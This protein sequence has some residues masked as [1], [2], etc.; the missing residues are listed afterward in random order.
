V[1]IST[2]DNIGEAFQSRGVKMKKPLILFPFL[3]AI[4]TI[5]LVYGLNGNQIHIRWLVRPFSVILL[6]SALV[7]WLARWMHR[8]RLRAG[9]TST[10][11]LLWLFSGH[12]H[13]AL[14]GMG[15]FASHP[16]RGLVL[17]AAW[18]SLLVFLGSRTLWQH[19]REQKR[20]TTYLNA[21]AVILLVFPSYRTFEFWGAIREKID[22]MEARRSQLPPLQL[23]PVSPPPDIYFIVLDAYGRADFLEEVYGYDNTEFIEFLVEKGFYVADRSS[24]NYPQTQLS[25]T[26]SLN[27]TYLND[28]TEGL[29]GSANR[30]PLNEMLQ[31]NT[32][33]QSLKNAGYSV[34]GLPS[35]VMFSRFSSADLY[36]PLT[37][38]EL[39]DFEQL[40]LSTTVA[41]VL[42]STGNLE[43]L[44]PGYET[45][46]VYI[47][48]ALETLKAVPVVPG[49]KFV[50]AHILA[51]HPPF[52]FDQYGNAVQPGY[53]YNMWD[54]AGFSGTREEYIA[55]YKNELTYLNQSLMDVISTILAE[56]RQPPIIII[57]GDHGPGAY[58]SFEELSKEG[59]L[60][61]R[62]SILNAYYFPGQQT[63][64]LYPTITPVNSFRVLFNTYFGTDLPILEDKNYYAAWLKPYEY[65]EIT[66]N[67]SQSASLCRQD[68]FND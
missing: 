47:K 17:L 30:A 8:D 36:Y 38:V 10:L 15:Q 16:V 52:V 20:L 35:A 40:L 27:M 26:S 50:F 68:S 11:F 60:W 19:L 57:Q 61:E 29:E 53:D 56:S 1:S 58:F 39:S 63:A 49:P 46:R 31:A 33:M 14:Y 51:P 32:V 4:Y 34:V 62:Y 13:H 43:L 3:F 18:S 48:R 66:G 2:P 28:W 54:G 67:F 12:L 37:P 64:G 21:V 42:P 44:I 22:V 7:Y 55:G 23:E 9:W 25:L 5:L 65:T 24:P 6:L 41:E 45:H 59:C